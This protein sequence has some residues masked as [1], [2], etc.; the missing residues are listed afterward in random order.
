MVGKAITVKTLDGDWAKA[1][2]AID[3]AKKDEVLVIHAG[4]GNLAVWG[5]LA[6][7][8]AIEKKLSGIVVDGGIRDVHE[9]IKTDIPVFAKKI[10]PQAGEPKGYGEIGGVIT[11]GTQQVK[12]GDWIVGD[13]SG[14]VVIPEEEAH[15]IANRALHVLERENRIREEIKRGSSLGKVLDVEKWEKVN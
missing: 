14:V 6:T 9:I 12:N 8:S 3:I 10:V 2:E 4:E 15:E 13:D 1:V 7:W 11:C 5:E